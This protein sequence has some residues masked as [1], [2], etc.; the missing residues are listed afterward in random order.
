MKE[1][2]NL[3]LVNPPG[4]KSKTKQFK[5]CDYLREKNEINAH[6]TYKSDNKPLKDENYYHSFDEWVSKNN[7]EKFIWP[8]N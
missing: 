1:K 3:L 6:I 4:S 8:N 5:V 7:D 2:M